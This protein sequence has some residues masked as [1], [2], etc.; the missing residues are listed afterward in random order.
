AASAMAITAVPALA[1]PPK[2]PAA[3]DVVGVGSDTIQNVLNQFSVSYNATHKS[4]PRLWSWD[5]TDPTTGAIGL[6]ITLKKGCK[7]I[8]RPN[9]SSGGIAALTTENASTGGHPCMD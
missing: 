6:P 7:Q 3:G 8:A 1:D 2:T 4:G 5:A 9:G